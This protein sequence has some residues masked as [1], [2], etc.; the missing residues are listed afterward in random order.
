M[1]E[2]HPEAF[3]PKLAIVLG[4]LGDRLAES[5]DESAALEA[6]RE[7]VEVGS[8]YR[9]L[10][11]DAGPA[12]QAHICLAEFL[13]ETGRGMEALAALDEAA[14]IL[15]PLAEEHD[16][17]LRDLIAVNEKRVSIL[18]AEDPSR[19]DPLA[20]QLAQQRTLYVQRTEATSPDS[21]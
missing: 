21:A 7:L 12:V 16:A 10:T 9:E 11:G 14:A 17:V 6:F 1:A 2:K 4:N 19:A 20:E 18:R 8:R 15:E 3:L 5:G 13:E